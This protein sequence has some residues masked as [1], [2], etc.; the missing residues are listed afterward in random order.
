MADLTPNFSGPS[1][2]GTHDNALLIASHLDLAEYPEQSFTLPPSTAVF[3]HHT[4]EQTL[5]QYSQ[6]I[7]TT[8]Q[9]QDEVFQLEP[10]S[11]EMPATDVWPERDTADHNLP[12]PARSPGSLSYESYLDADPILHSTMGLPASKHF[13]EQGTA[14]SEP[15]D[16]AIGLQCTDDDLFGPW[17]VRA[18]TG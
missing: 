3:G 18:R 10:R 5:P 6:Q 11:G 13:P 1:L 9:L 17:A 12:M 16:G 14:A 7:G 15:L 4:W 2:N 8:Q